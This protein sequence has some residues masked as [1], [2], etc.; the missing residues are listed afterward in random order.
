MQK[1]FKSDHLALVHE[2]NYRWI[3]TFYKKHIKNK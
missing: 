3:K 1:E 2:V